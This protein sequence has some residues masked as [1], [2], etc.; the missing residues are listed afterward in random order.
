M[1]TQ[2]LRTSNGTMYTWIPDSNTIFA[3]SGST[4][5]T[6]RQLDGLHHG[7]ELSTAK[8]RHCSRQSSATAK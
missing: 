4:W 8:Q 6:P 7:G 1:P 3:A 5:T 2:P